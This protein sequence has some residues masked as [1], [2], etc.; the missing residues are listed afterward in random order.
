VSQSDID[1]VKRFVEKPSDFV[2][3]RQPGMSAAQVAGPNP[4][5][6]YAPQSTQIQGILKGMYDAFTSE[7]EKD[8]AEEADK[9]KSFEEIWATKM[10]EQ[11]TLK[12]TLLK[13]ETDLAA[14]NKKL[15]QSE[16][17]LDDT[18][19]QMK[20]DEKFFEE[21]K[22]TCQA[23]ATEW[24]V[25]TRLR[26]EE[27]NGM[28]VAIK[29]L[30]SPEA[31]KTFESATTTFVQLASV[32]RHKHTESSGDRSKAYSMLKKLATQVSSSKVAKIAVEVKAGGHFDKVIAMVD[33]MIALLRKEEQADIEQRDRCQRSEN[34]NKNEMADLDHEIEK[35]EASLERME[36]K[37]KEI[38]EEIAKLESDINGTNEDMAE[39]LEFRNGEVAEFRQAMKDDSDAI[40]LLKQAIVALEKY[41]KEN[42]LPIPELLQRE[43]PEY[44]HDPDK[45]PELEFAGSESRKGETGGILA[46]LEMLVE[47]LEKEEK[48]AKADDADSQDKYLK[49][50][51]ALEE[52]LAS[53]EETLVNLETELADLEEKMRSYD[54]YKDEKSADK[55]AE[56]D[57]KK[58]IYTDCSWVK[59][60][61]ESRREKRKVEIQGLVDA[62]AF[63]AGVAAGEDPLPPQ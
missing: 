31:Q 17:L 60:H 33:T 23:K 18:E 37:K 16:T 14:Q 8:N 36:N 43:D 25:R 12:E 34:A 47:D 57:M 44:T 15:A 9:Q 5:G 6:D 40:G 13:Q 30:S 29:I 41:Y 11:K 53:Q 27:L 61:F 58:G 48:E 26:T 10:E 32:H 7:L 19:A 3:H 49:Q 62:K 38:E 24:S 52:T 42:N 46:I 35:T 1:I 51:G 4:F 56:E 54:K 39:L 22:E 50:R 45:A 59:T 2:T 20:A 55:D 28:Q 63:L 21:T